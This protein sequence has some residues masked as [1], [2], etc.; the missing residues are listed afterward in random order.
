VYPLQKR[1]KYMS[2]RIKDLFRIYVSF[3]LALAVLPAI[4]AAQA[5]TTS[6]S[7]EI[8]AIAKELGQFVMPRS[9]PFK[10]DEIKIANQT[11]IAN[12]ARSGH[13]DSHAEAFAHWDSEGEIPP[14]CATCHSGAGFRSFHG[15][16][17][18][19]PGVKKEP[20]PIGGVVD[21]DTCH[22]PA[23]NKVTEV[24]FPSGLMHPVAT[25]AEASCMTC[26]QGRAAGNMISKAVATLEPDAPNPELKFINPH[27]AVAAATWLGGYGGSG[28]QYPG[29]DYSGRFFHARPVETCVSCHEP[30]SLKV[31]Q[32]ACST[33]HE[34]GKLDN[35]RLSRIS[36]DGSGDLKKGLRADLAANAERLHGLII[37][38][39]TKV[40]GVPMVFD[41]H[42]FPYFF[43]DANGDGRIDEEN[44][45]AVAYNAWTPR[46]LQATYN[47]KFVTSDKG[48]FVH[49]PHYALELVYDS[50]QD[51]AGPMGLDFQ[52][53]NMMR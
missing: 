27:Y 17:G 31:A 3:G 42:R 24:K 23:L 40:A 4:G 48:A 7:P 15:L 30:H 46:L 11:A 34:D 20:T 29:K 9:G 41:D 32:D 38:Y 49:N 18:S 13:S 19:A 22:N 21:C 33:C 5:Q 26:H 47:W 39:A 37:D 43:A 16:D 1:K 50:T 14:A 6:T 45:N 2:L 36:Y 51:L 52:A 25:T 8:E 44:G 12:W 10:P 28:F 35:I 53:W